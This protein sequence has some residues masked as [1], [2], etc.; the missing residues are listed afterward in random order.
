MESGRLLN[1]EGSTLVLYHG[2]GETFTAFKAEFIGSKHVDIIRED[3]AGED[4]DPTAFYFT[5]DMATAIWYATSAAQKL[6]KKANEGVVVSVSLSMSKPKTVNFQRQGREYLGEELAAAKLNGH[7]GLICRSYDDG[8]V[9]DHYIVFDACQIN[10]LKT[11]TVREI[12]QVQAPDDIEQKNQG[13]PIPTELPESVIA[14]AKRY[15]LHNE[16]GE[17]L[18]SEDQ[19]DPQYATLCI[20]RWLTAR[21]GQIRLEVRIIQREKNSDDFW[22]CGQNIQSEPITESDAL[23]LVNHWG[24]TSQAAIQLSQQNERAERERLDAWGPRPKQPWE[25]EP[26]QTTLHEQPEPAGMQP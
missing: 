1:A 11:V 8:G 25:V 23:Q 21:S 22:P 5:T 24:R 3:C 15:G 7:D 18:Y 6:G 16:V 13:Q 17:I 26:A 14:L 12:E 4:I 10:I 2:T 19:G 9:S 20:D